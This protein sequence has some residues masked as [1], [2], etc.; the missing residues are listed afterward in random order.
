MQ[1][2]G[3]IVDDNSS[4]LCGRDIFVHYTA[5]CMEQGFRCLSTN[6]AVEYDLRKGFGGRMQALNVCGAYGEPCSGIGALQ[7]D[8]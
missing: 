6:E 1:G 7:L 3:Y 4:V 2:Y 8:P 5:I